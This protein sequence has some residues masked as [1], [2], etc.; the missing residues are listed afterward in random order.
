MNKFQNSLL[1]VSGGVDSMSLL[2]FFIKKKVKFD[3]LHINHLTRGLENEKEYQLIKQ[4]AIKNK[5]RLHYF[6][7]QHQQGNFQAKA[8]EFR[9]K[10]ASKVCQEEQLTS[11]ITAHHRDDLVEN[12]MMNN[13]RLGS[14]LITKH[15]ELNGILIIR[16]LLDY[17]KADIYHYAKEEQIKYYEDYSNENPKYKRN[18][19]RLQLKQKSQMEK[20]T[21]IDEEAKRIANFP[22]VNPDLTVSELK[23]HDR[24]NQELILYLWL[25]AKITANISRTL[26][27]DIL[28]RINA[29][30]T[31]EYSLPE[32]WILYKNYDQLQLT[33]KIIFTEPEIIK[34]A[35]IG[36][37]EFNGIYFIN[38][39][40]DAII[41]C[42]KDGDRIK[43]REFSKKVSRVMIDLKI[44]KNLRM[45]WP[46]VCDKQGNPLYIPKQLKK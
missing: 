39:I 25:K 35:I 24:Y 44:P 26:I 8:R 12:I 1:L 31:K 46:V 13:E 15:S 14:K 10:M 29:Y 37:N 2:H 4:I 5:I 38:N 45:I 7:Y 27:T 42:R 30:G 28:K 32:G 21:I 20:E 23:K 22:S 11:I 6:E 18:Y 19:I 9:Y 36:K 16:P 41:R 17:Y 40:E 43:Y 34:K 3:I 33:K